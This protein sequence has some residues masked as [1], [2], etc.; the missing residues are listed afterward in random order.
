MGTDLSHG[1]SR[2]ELVGEGPLIDYIQMIA[3]L[4]YYARMGS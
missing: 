2:G 1:K 3:V 4:N